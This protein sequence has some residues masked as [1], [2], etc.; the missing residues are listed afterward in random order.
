MYG[1][2]MSTLR[3][4]EIT[5]RRQSGSSSSDG[6]SKTVAASRKLRKRPCVVDARPENALPGYTKASQHTKVCQ[7]LVDRSG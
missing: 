1:A 3:L 6:L 7:R 4:A 2:L 5:Q